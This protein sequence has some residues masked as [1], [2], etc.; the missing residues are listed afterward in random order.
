MS[1]NGGELSMDNRPRLILEVFTFFMDQYEKYGT[2]YGA[3][4]VA[5]VAGVFL[6]ANPELAKQ[7]NATRM[8]VIMAILYIKEAWS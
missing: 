2:T 8:E 5:E 1:S 4:T 3:W 6:D 7:V